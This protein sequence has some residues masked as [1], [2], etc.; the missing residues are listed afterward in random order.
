VTIC[1]GMAMNLWTTELKDGVVVASYYNPPMN[2]FCAAGTQEL[3]ELIEA[4][5]EPST[6]STW[7]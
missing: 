4:W 3:V 2:Y 5:R 1:E 7:Q 6:Q